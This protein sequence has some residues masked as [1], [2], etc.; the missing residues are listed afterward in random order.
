MSGAAV[1][2]RRPRS[3]RGQGDQLAVEI[4]DA[5]STLIEKAGHADAVSIDDVVGKVGCTPPALYRH[6]RS[7]HELFMA[8][9]ARQ[10]SGLAE[11]LDST[12]AGAGSG[13][14]EL[15]A[16]GRG[17]V[18]WGLAHPDSYRT[19]FVHRPWEPMSSDVVER[20]QAVVDGLAAAAQRGVDDGEL[21]GDA[22]TIATAVWAAAHG[23]TSLLL[24]EPDRSWPDHDSLIEATIDGV[25]AGA[26]KR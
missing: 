10:V 13:G 2:Y 23:L 26:A 18:A 5:A 19:A 21:A 9:A 3:K 1:P 20:V 4:L 17:Y 24:A 8:V 6:F 12:T 16:R 14:A 25:V 22:A 11:T 7:K 15:A